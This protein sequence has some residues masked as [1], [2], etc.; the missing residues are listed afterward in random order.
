MSFAEHL[1]GRFDLVHRYSEETQRGTEQFIQVL[2][3]RAL[4]EETYARGLERISS[5]TS[6][7][8][9][10][11]SLAEAINALKSDSLN[12]AAQAKMLAEKYNLIQRKE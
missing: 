6:P 9:T 8:S 7:L 2:R 5:H 1:P 12:K 10:R 4:L 11:G 3:E